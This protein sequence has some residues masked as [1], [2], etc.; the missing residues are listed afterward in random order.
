M[1][2]ISVVLP[3]YNRAELLYKAIDSVLKQTIQD[4]ELLVV[5]DFSTDNTY[6]IVNRY[7]DKRIKYIKNERNKGANGAR[8]T[9]ILLAKGDYIAFQDSDDEWFN[10][11]LEK[12]LN[13]MNE[14]QDIDMCFCSFFLHKKSE[15]IIF[16]NLKL[17][18]KNIPKK[19]KIGSFI[20]TQT[21][22]CRSSCAKAILFDED[23]NRLQDWEFCLRFSKVYKIGYLDKPLVN[24]YFEENSITTNTDIHEVVAKIIK[25][26]GLE[27][28]AYEFKMEYYRK[29]ILSKGN[30]SLHTNFINFLLYRFYKVLKFVHYKII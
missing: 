20:S 26:H 10:D 21:I 9:G 3:T 27:K 4:I 1:P 25:K 19:L 13:F 30:Y 17:H 11:K 6:E 2:I 18:V 15:R 5:D 28:K 23:I 7:K 24:V 22:F 29:E 14:N 16:P 8:N 12:Q